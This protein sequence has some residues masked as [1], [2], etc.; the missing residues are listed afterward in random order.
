[1]F[2]LSFLAQ[3]AFEIP[4]DLFSINGAAYLLPFFLAGIG[5]S[6][7]PQAARS[8]TV[9]YG[10]LAVFGVTM[11]A[12]LLLCLTGG[13]LPARGTVWG[14]TIG[15]SGCLTLMTVMPPMRWMA[16]V[17]GFSFTIY[18]YH[19]IL[20]TG[21]RVLLGNFGVASLSTH[22]AAGMVAG[23]AGGIFLELLLR[24]QPSTR[25]LLI[26]K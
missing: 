10:T 22:A 19:G 11:T 4:Y 12:Y 13:E 24:N 25:R 21:T 7:F 8:P 6:R 1:M 3:T 20:V 18:L 16:W 26:G 23:I 15:L 9:R 17:G 2:A 14:T 5:M